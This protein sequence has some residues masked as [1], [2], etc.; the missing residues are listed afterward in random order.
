MTGDMPA[1]LTQ[2]RVGLATRLAASLGHL[3][4]PVAVVSACQPA[5]S[6]VV[7]NE[8]SGV[9]LVVRVTTQTARQSW[10]VPPGGNALLFYQQAPLEGVVELVDPLTCEVFDKDTLPSSPTVIEPGS[11]DTQPPDYELGMIEDRANRGPLA[12]PNFKGC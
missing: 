11:L 3:I 8:N 10:L 5:W 6:V 4:L 1:T 2:N 12:A 9:P 7:V